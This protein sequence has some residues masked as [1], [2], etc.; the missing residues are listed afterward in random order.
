MA[1][2]R[3]RRPKVTLLTVLCVLVLTVAG[4]C[5]VAGP[6]I[7]PLN[8]NTQDIVLGATAPS[9]E[10]LLGT[11]DL[12]R[13]VFSRLIA[14]A[15]TA[16]LGAVVVAIGATLVGT[17]VGLVAG[18]R[19]GALDSFLMRV[20]DLVWAFPMLLTTLVVVGVF[21]GGYWVAV[22]MFTI[23]GWPIEARLVRS[24]TLV[25]RTLPYVEAA[26]TL[27]VS[28]PV[29]VFRHVL[30]N[31]APT[32]VA[33]LLLGFVGA[34]VGLSGLSFLGLGVPPGVPDWGLMINENRSILET[35]IWGSLAPSI[36]L[37]IVGLAATLAADR[38]YSKVSKEG[39][40]R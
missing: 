39:S 6:F 9:G 7:T 1:K 24:V 17:V 3:A 20:T 25:Q 32:V 11:D 23:F 34:L 18:F 35:N 15:Q 40:S 26:R 33:N 31:V 14:G 28:E 16:I 29:I 30:P 4:V 10:H 19:G 8:P 36:A 22:A 21:D 5:A 37:I 12:G 27:D 13:D 38:W 2:E